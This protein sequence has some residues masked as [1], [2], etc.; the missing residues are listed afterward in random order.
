MTS[1]GIALAEERLDLAEERPLVDADER[2]RVAGRSGPARPADPVDVV[3]GDHRQLVVDD[4]RQ[5]LDVEAARGDL[6]RDEDRGAA[7][8]EVVER[9]DPLAL[10]LVAVDRGRGDAV[11]GELLG[12]AVRAVLRPGEDERLLD[13]AGP[14]EVAQQ[15]ALAL[16]VDR[17][18]ELRDELGRRVPRA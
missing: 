13:A 11:A 10:A 6:G 7:G 18:D 3:L 9:P 12:E 15:L 1:V 2:D 8:L 14:D 16:A 4:V 17:E 5:L